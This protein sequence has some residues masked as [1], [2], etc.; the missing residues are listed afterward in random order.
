MKLL[1][2]GPVLNDAPNDTIKAFWIKLNWMLE[3]LI[4]KKHVICLE[5]L[6]IKFGYVFDGQV[7][8]RDALRNSNQLRHNIVQNMIN[9]LL[10]TSIKSVCILPLKLSKNSINLIKFWFCQPFG[11]FIYRQKAE[12][13]ETEDQYPNFFDI[14]SSPW[15]YKVVLSRWSDKRIHRNIIMTQRG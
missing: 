8:E 12:T 5:Y 3:K 10:Q 1:P 15:K 13:S 2:Y 14:T 4:E 6:E 9:L 7:S 11:D